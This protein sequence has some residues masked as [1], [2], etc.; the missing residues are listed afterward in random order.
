MVHAR[1]PHRKER[2][3]LTLPSSNHPPSCYHTPTMNDLPSVMKR[4]K[5]AKSKRQDLNRLVR[6]MLD[7]STSY[8]KLTDELTELRAKKKRIENEVRSECASELQEAEKLAQSIKADTQLLTDIALTKF[9]KGES[10]EVVDEND[11]KY[12]PV[13][14]VS[15]KKVS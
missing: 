2:V 3:I 13:F 8:K 6:D 1:Y 12:E 4:I 15:F 9:M 7:Q 5:A 14:K 11:T 10:I